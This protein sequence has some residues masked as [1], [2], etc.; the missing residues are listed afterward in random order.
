MSRNIYFLLLAL[1][2]GSAAL[3]AR[4]QNQTTPPSAGSSL[5]PEQLMAKEKAI[6]EHAK[7]RA[8][9]KKQAK[10]AGL[11]LTERHK[12]VKDCMAEK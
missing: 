5:S 8:A 6:E 7:K 4:A 12:F 11:G 10:E 1:I 2:L 9:C 3:P